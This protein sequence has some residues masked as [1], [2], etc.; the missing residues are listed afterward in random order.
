MTDKRVLRELVR[1]QQTAQALQAYGIYFRALDIY[2][3]T[4]AVMKHQP[5]GAVQ[6]AN[7][8]AIRVT[9]DNY[10]SSKIYTCQ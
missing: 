10:P 2:R 4:K 1:P 8:K 5:I 3:R 6:S 7:T 9:S